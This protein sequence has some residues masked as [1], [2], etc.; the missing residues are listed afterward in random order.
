MRDLVQY[1]SSWRDKMVKLSKSDALRILGNVPLENR[2]WCC[3]GAVLNN[4]QELESALNNMSEES[5]KHH[6]NDERN[7]FT[8]WVKEIIKDEKLAKDLS[9]AK[10]KAT[11]VKK[12]NARIK[13]MSNVLK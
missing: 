9:K 2:F 1:L 11:A 4:L 7:D 5:F 8:N 13:T 12:V 3:N 6:A 10:T